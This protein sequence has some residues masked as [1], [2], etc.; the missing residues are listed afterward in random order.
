[1]NC[2]K[3]EP[4]PTTLRDMRQ[5]GPYPHVTHI[6]GVSAKPGFTAWLPEP[7]LMAT[8]RLPRSAGETEEPRS[9]CGGEDALVPAETGAADR[10]AKLRTGERMAGVGVS[11]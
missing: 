5:L 9:G 10:T 4:R 8:L 6:L 1:L 3:E 7:A 11:T 2:R